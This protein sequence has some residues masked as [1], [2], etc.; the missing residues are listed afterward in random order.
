MRFSVFRKLEENSRIFHSSRAAALAQQQSSII[1]TRSKKHFS[2]FFTR[3]Y[4]LAASRVFFFARAYNES[5]DE[6]SIFFVSAKFVIVTAA[7]RQ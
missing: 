1:W 7:A 2:K 5:A 6:T 4:A 3:R